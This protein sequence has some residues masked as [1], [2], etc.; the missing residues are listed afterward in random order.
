MTCDCESSVRES[1]SIIEDRNFALFNRGFEDAII[2]RIF[3]KPRGKDDDD[4][5]KKKGKKASSKISLKKKKSPFKDIL[6]SNS[7]SKNVSTFKLCYFFLHT[8]ISC[9]SQWLIK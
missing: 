4:D 1:R 9:V 8:E 6:K 3:V 7:R 2:K 5:E